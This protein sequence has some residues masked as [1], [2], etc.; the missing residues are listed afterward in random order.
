MPDYQA[1]DLKNPTSKSTILITFPD[2][3]I[4]EVFST[5]TQVFSTITQVFSTITEV[6]STT[7]NCIHTR[8]EVYS[9]ITQVF[10]TITEVFSTTT[11]VLFKA[12]K[13]EI[14]DFESKKMEVVAGYD[15]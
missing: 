13:R 9:I 4:I 2:F 6:F 15:V 7:I 8:T 10:S 14:F 1:V 5:I 11:I 12:T 3:S